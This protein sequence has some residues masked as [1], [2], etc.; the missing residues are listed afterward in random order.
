MQIII[1]NSYIERWIEGKPGTIKVFEIAL[2]YMAKDT[3]LTFSKKMG[4]RKPCVF[5]LPLA[6]N[7]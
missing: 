4:G 2:N 1:S 6:K 3:F 7:V 5:S